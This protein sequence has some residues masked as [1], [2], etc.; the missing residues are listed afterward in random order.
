MQLELV[1]L[2]NPSWSLWPLKPLPSLPVSLL[3]HQS[4]LCSPLSSAA[5]RI[6]GAVCLSTP[7]YIVVCSFVIYARRVVSV[8]REEGSREKKRN[9]CET[10]SVLLP[11][12]LPNFSIVRGSEGVLVFCS[13]NIRTIVTINEHQL[14][15]LLNT[16]L[17]QHT[18][19]R[20][21]YGDVIL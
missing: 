5:G 16:R 20:G 9:K 3:L 8:Q 14:S 11:A 18:V 13:R 1:I 17:N 21:R 7:S 4:H 10:K 6:Q 2:K 15:Q 12:R 19:G